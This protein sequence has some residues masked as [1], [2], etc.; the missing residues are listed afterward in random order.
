MKLI[1]LI[2]FILIATLNIKKYFIYLNL[3]KSYKNYINSLK[4]LRNIN[5]NK[6]SKDIQIFDNISRFGLIL[7]LKLVALLFP[8]LILF[9]IL[10]LFNFNYFIKIVISAIPYLN[11]LKR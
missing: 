10:Q 2:I 4:G 9:T 3:V 1:F 6:D 5:F 8:F 7:L 11:L